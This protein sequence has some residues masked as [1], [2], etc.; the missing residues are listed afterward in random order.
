[1]R[2]TAFKCLD[3]IASTFMGLDVRIV[4]PALPWLFTTDRRGKGCPTTLFRYNINEAWTKVS[5]P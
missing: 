5:A 2:S 4:T 1:M 3:I